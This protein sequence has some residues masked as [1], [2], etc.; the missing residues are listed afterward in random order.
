[1]NTTEIVDIEKKP[2]RKEIVFLCSVKRRKIQK[3]EHSDVI[4]IFFC[5]CL[6]I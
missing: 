6:E 5:M 4:L 2:A 3:D 1:M